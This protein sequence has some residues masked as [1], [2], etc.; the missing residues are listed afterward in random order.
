MKSATTTTHCSTI[1]EDLMREAWAQPRTARSSAYKAGTY[2][3]L[4]YQL[5]REDDCLNPYRLGTAEA[6]AFWA[7]V[8]EG[9]LIL[10]NR[11]IA[12]R[13]HAD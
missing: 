5:G 9:W 10:R 11:G 2:D 12:P 7:G 1:V 3:L 6:D 4:C 13:H 8:D